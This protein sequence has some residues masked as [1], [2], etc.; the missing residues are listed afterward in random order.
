MEFEATF[1]DLGATSSRGTATAGAWALLK[2]DPQVISRKLFTRAQSTSGAVQRGLRPA[3]HANDA[4]CDYKK[5]PFFNVLAAFWIQFMTHDWF[6]HLDDG[7]NARRT[8]MTLGCAIDS[9]MASSAAD[10]GA[11][12]RLGCRPGDRIDAALIADA[13]ARDIH[14]RRRDAI[15]TRA[16]KTTRNTITAWW[17]ASQLYGYDERSAQRVKRDPGDPAR[18]TD[19]PGRC[20]RGDGDDAGLSAAVCSA[21]DPINPQWSGQEATAFPDNWTIGLSFFHNVFAREHNPFVDAFRGKARAHPDADSG[22]RNPAR[23]DAVI[24]YRDVDARRAVRGRAPRRRRGNR[25]DPHDRVDDAAAV[26]RAAVPRHERATGRPARARTTQ[27]RAALEDMSCADFG[28][29]DDAEV[30]R[31]HGTRCSHPVP[32]SSGSAI[33]SIPMRSRRSAHADLWSIAQPD[34]V[35]GGVNHFGSPFNFPE[36]FVTVYRLHPLVPDLIE[37]REWNTTRT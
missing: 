5:A 24:R 12:C 1:P 29:S 18:L 20:R 7:H 35:N 4:H 19:G 37:Y 10:A 3:G 2:P 13:P 15:S 25:E 23:P 36:E 28:A 30:E 6:S 14:A 32:A 31:Q 26:R 11:T 33:T 9:R 22:L 17:D 34:H 21:G 16:P 8:D 27:C